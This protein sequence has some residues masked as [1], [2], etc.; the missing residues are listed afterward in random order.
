M[1]TSHGVVEESLIRHYFATVNNVKGNQVKGWKKSRGRNSG[2]KEQ[3]IRYW[4]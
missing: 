3:K 1:L 2:Q 4:S